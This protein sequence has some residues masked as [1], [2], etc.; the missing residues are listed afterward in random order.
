MSIFSKAFWKD[1]IERVVSTAAG[2][3]ITVATA[4]Q[5]GQLH[6]H[7]SLIL[8][9]IGVPAL[10]SFLKALAATKVDST[11]SPASLAK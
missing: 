10:V 3:A 4:D 11:V 8:T 9:L 2:A 6:A 7:P 5:L 1:A